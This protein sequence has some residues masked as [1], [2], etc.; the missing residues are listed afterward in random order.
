[1]VNVVRAKPKKDHELYLRFDDGVSGTVDIASVVEF[2][3]VF[4]ALADRKEFRKVSVNR[5]LGVVCW[6]NGADLDSLVL[7]SKITGKPIVL[8]PPTYG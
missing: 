6:P 4:K 8:N 1:M 5:E 2:T 3:G 7:H